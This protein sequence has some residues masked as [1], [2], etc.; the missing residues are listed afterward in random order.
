MDIGTCQEIVIFLDFAAA[1]K[2][3]FPAGNIAFQGLQK[4]ENQVFPP[5]KSRFFSVKKSVFWFKKSGYLDTHG[6]EPVESAIHREKAG[7]LKFLIKHA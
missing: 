2:M 7:F 4:G 5:A 1:E 3:V 6:K